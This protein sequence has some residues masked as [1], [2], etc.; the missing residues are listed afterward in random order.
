MKINNQ[1]IKY[2]YSGLMVIAMANIANGE[3]SRYSMSNYFAAREDSR[4]SMSD[5]LAEEDCNYAKKVSKANIKAEDN[6]IL[7]EEYNLVWRA[8]KKEGS[9]LSRRDKEFLM[10]ISGTVISAKRKDGKI[11]LIHKASLAKGDDKS[12][13]KMFFGE[14]EKQVSSSFKLYSCEGDDC[15][16]PSQLDQMWT[17]QNSMINKVEEVIRSIEEKIKVEDKGENVTL[18]AREKYFLNKTTF[19]ILKTIL[20][21][22]REGQVERYIVGDYAKTLSLDY[23]IGYL[24][25]LIDFAHEL[26]NNLERTQIKGMTSFNSSLGLNKF[27]KEIKVMRLALSKKRYEV[28]KKLLRRYEKPKSDTAK[29][30]SNPYDSD[31]ELDSKNTDECVIKAM[32]MKEAKLLL[33]LWKNVEMER[34]RGK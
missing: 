34:N 28:L 2:F 6:R 29:E 19:P 13:D 32:K 17:K 1:I 5:Y 3:D 25:G 18:N 23:I 9:D 20:I 11:I 16:H 26:Q 24:D 8:F 4:L 33:G 12:L 14:A 21:A 27:I 30:V 15:L 31:K 10:S 22:S 7:S